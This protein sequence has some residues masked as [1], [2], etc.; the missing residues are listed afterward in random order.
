[1]EKGSEIN[2]IL[3]RYGVGQYHHKLKS[4]KATHDKYHK[5][6]TA[7]MICMFASICH[8]DSN[9]CL[10]QPPLAN[11]I[12]FLLNSDGQAY[13]LLS[14]QHNSIQQKQLRLRKRN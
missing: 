7:H 14:L 12:Y 5:L 4:I 10:Q 9:Y 6:S 1:M 13:R 2:K 8:F 3:N 11:C